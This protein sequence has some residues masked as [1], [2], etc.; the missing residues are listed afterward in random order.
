MKCYLYI[1]NDKIGKVE[2]EVI[3]VSMDAISGDLI[4]ARFDLIYRI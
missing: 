1:G 2:F 4:S 3:D